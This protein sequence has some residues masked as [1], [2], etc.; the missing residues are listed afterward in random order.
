MTVLRTCICCVTPILVACC[1]CSRAV[2]LHALVTGPEQSDSEFLWQ[3]FAAKNN[4]E[5]LANLGNLCNRTLVFVAKQMGGKLLPIA[6]QEADRA[7]I[8]RVEGQVGREER[9]CVACHVC[10]MMRVYACVIASHVCMF[11]AHAHVIPLHVMMRVV[12]F[13]F[14]RSH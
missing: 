8:K 10:M 9:M 3:D 1:S 11:H 6:V 4:N 12:M 14:P 7:F 5:L 13:P 2:V